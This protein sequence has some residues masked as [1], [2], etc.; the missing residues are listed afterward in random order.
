MLQA[1]VQAPKDDEIIKQFKENYPHL[2]QIKVYPTVA[3]N[4]FLV[5]T[6]VTRYGCFSYCLT[7]HERK[8]LTSHRGIRKSEISNISKKLNEDLSTWA[9][10]LADFEIKRDEDIKSEIHSNK[11]KSILYDHL[12]WFIDINGK[13]FIK[14]SELAR[15]ARGKYSLF[16]LS[17]LKLEETL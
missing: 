8:R 14:I 7:N 4:V 3:R 9:N 1:N 13:S 5:I 15:A 16:C 6:K 2:H 11:I 17:V 12:S 10:L